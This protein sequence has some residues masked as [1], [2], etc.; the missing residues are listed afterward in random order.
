MAVVAA[1]QEQVLHQTK[2]AL[3]GA[4]AVAAVQVTMVDQVVVAVVRVVRG[5]VVQVVAV[6]ELPRPGAR[7]AVEVRQVV[8]AV[9]LVAQTPALEAPVV[10]RATTSSAI[11]L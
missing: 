6:V 8:A 2:A 11:R 3:I 10:L 4:V 7:E 1:E 9:L 5:Q